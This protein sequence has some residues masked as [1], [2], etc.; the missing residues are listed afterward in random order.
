MALAD[1]MKNFVNDVK[2]SRR[3][4]HEFV[5]G[6]R[7]I[8]K[9]IMEENNKFLQNIHAQNKTN[10][11]QLHAFLKSSK[12]DRLESFSQLMENIHGDLARIHEAKEAIAQGSRAMM[13]EFRE[14]AQMA[15][16]YWASLSD[17]NPIED[18]SV[19]QNDN[20][21]EEPSAAQEDEDT[22]E[23]E[24]STVEDSE[25]AEEPEKE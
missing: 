16:T 25:L 3:S 5:K 14:D 22:E 15:H 17:D 7:Q 19:A 2:A 1:S 12:E 23:K 4:R 13:K 8:T 18:V 11:D 10:A 24:P 9:N 20:P 6:N 21:I